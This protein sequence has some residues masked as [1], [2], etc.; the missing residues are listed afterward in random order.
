[1]K[2]DNAY[3]MMT[4]DDSF[5]RDDPT[6]DASAFLEWLDETAQSEGTSGEELLQTLVSSYWT[7][8]EMF[9]LLEEAEPESE[10]SRSIGSSELQRRDREDDLSDVEDAL[11][12]RI[13]DLDDRFRRHREAVRDEP[14][15][16][17]S[18]FE[19]LADRIEALERAVQQLAEPSTGEDEVFA[20]LV[21]RLADVE[22]E[23]DERHR[24]LRDRV[25]EEFG[26][27]RGILDHLLDATDRLDGQVAGL[28]DR[29]DGV[30]ESLDPDQYRLTEIKRRA[31]RLGVSEARCG[32]C[33]T[34][35]DIALLPTPYCPQ[36]DRPFDGVRPKR[37]WFG[38]ATLTVGAGTDATSA[39]FAPVDRRASVARH[40]FRWGED[41]S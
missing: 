9:R 14:G 37:G 11:T 33:D 39:G 15:E 30:Q 29:L 22:D 27:L 41:R 4:Y 5:D 19:S 7:L 25:T 40:G 34:L 1:M 32:Y 21:E 20:A 13:D 17:A 35:V 31:A 8:D 10:L 16:L 12:E 28:G 18:E 23:F 24:S 6:V 38:S 2:G 26:Y 3:E 36:C